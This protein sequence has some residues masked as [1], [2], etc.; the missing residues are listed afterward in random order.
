[1]LWFSNVRRIEGLHTL[2]LTQLTGN[3]SDKNKPADRCN[4]GPMCGAGPFERGACSSVLTPFRRKIYVVSEGAGVKETR[5][6]EASKTPKW[7]GAPSGRN[8]TT[9]STR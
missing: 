2:I 3:L 5:P 7:I 9:F 4:P 8:E 1:M 6:D